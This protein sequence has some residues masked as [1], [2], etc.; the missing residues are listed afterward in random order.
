MF[1]WYRQML[2]IR[3]FEDTVLR[4]RQEQKII[5]SVH[6]C[7]GQEAVPVGAVAARESGDPVFATYR[8]HGWALACGVPPE[9]VMAELCARESGVNGGRGGSAYFTAPEW[10]F[11]GENSIVGAGAPIGAGSALAA[12]FDGSRA[13]TIT[14]FGEGALNQGSVHEALNFASVM[15]LPMVFVCE[16]NKYSELTPISSMVRVAQ[17]SSRASAY[18]MPG[19][20]V[21]GNDPAAV[22]EAA[23]IAINRA[24]A[25]DGPTLIEAMTYRIVGHYV[26]DP[27][28][29]RPKGELEDAM[30]AEPLVRAQKT[31]LGSAV[32]E[33]DLTAVEREVAAVLERAVGYALASP[34][35]D[36]ASVLDH[37]VG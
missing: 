11:Y 7:N 12:K 23:L 8:G 30:A 36:P 3:R 28:T 6:L 18:G 26:G 29:Y 10:G 1:G 33:D 2:L 16:N 37:I 34:E 21:D 32:G 13:V 24:R 14:V 5:G 19:V 15:R 4:L 31:L 17:L 22:H 9:L 27:E 35:A 25:G 20:T